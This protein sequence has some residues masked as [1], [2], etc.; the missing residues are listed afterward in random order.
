MALS[1]PFRANFPVDIFGDLNQLKPVIDSYV[2][3][4][5][6]GS[7]LSVIAGPVLW[8]KVKYFRLNTIMRQRDDQY[9]TTALNHLANGQLIDED[10]SLF[11]SRLFPN[12]S[13][14][15]PLSAI[16]FFRLNE[17]VERFNRRVIESIDLSLVYKCTARD[18]CSNQ[19]KGERSSDF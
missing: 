11:R 12:T 6:Y 8:Q 18:S 4:A 17:K 2:F 13:L 14:L 10:K 5:P 9:F 16:R 1:H 15:L 3:K 7:D 19:M